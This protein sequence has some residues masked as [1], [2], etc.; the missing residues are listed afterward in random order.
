MKFSGE[1]DVD[2]DEVQCIIA[3][4]IDKV[5]GREGGRERGR[6]GEREGGRGWEEMRERGRGTDSLYPNH[7]NTLCG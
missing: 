4:L 1:E 7:H 5:R 2:I 6:E 3:N